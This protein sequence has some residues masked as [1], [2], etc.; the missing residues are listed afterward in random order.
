MVNFVIKSVNFEV[1]IS[2]GNE[3]IVFEIKMVDFGV[4][5][6]DSQQDSLFSDQKWHILG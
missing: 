3:M 4:K 1:E 2:F 5:M 6:V